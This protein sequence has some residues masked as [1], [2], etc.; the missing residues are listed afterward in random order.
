M[1]MD[2]K[3]GASAE[4]VFTKPTGKTLDAIVTITL[5][6]VAKDLS[7]T[8]T[9]T[10][11]TKVQELEAVCGY[12]SLDD[13]EDIGSFY[14]IEAYDITAERAGTGTRVEQNKPN[15]RVKQNY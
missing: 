2:L 15:Y 7:A 9:V 11:S 14:K 1:V 12:A 10:K 13:K 5:T 3:P 6:K 8:M 4:V